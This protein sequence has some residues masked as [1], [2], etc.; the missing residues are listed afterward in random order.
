MATVPRIPSAKEQQLLRLAKRELVCRQAR[1]GDIEPY[2]Q[3][4]WPELEL[5]GFQLDILRSLFDPSIR[6]VFAKGNTGCGKSA[7]AGIA[8]AAWFDVFDPAKVVITSAQYEHAK[9][10]VYGE[11]LKWWRAR[12]LPGATYKP[13]GSECFD[14]EEHYV[15]V[16]N[17]AVDVAFSCGLSPGSLFVFV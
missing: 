10:V 14:D 5:D 2:V 7:I 9:A 13:S 11:F 15:A 12:R 3:A 4:Q 8:I 16:V 17:P 1:K 6:E